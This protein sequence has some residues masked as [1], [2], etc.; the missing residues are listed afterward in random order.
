MTTKNNSQIS[1][2][3]RPICRRGVIWITKLC[4][5]KCKFCYYLYEKGKTHT[6]FDSIE[7]TIKWFKN[8][9]HLEYVDIP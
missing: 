6:S 5:I 9:Y 2:H 8:Q 1:K 7:R 3:N 4:N